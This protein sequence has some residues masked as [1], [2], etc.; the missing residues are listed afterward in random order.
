MLVIHKISPKFVRVL[1]NMYTKLEGIVKVNGQISQP[2]DIERGLR[3][4]C[5]MSPHLF[6]IYI[7]ELPELLQRA[8]CDPVLVHDKKINILMYAD[9]ML[10]LSY[11]Q[12]GLQ[13]ALYILEA[14]CNKWQLV[15]N[16]HKTKIMIFNKRKY[17]N[18]QFLYK[19][20]LLNITKTYIYLGI[21]ITPSGS[22]TQTT[23]DLSI[24]AK[25]ALFSL[26]SSLRKVQTNPQLTL[27]LFD[28]LIKPIALY[29]CD[30]WGAFGLRTRDLNSLLNVILDADHKSFE[31]LNTSVCKQALHINKKASNLGAKAEL[32]R[33]PMAVTII[34]SIV[35]YFHRLKHAKANSLL[36]CALQSQL[37]KTRNYGNTL[38]YPI[39]AI[40]LI[41]Q[42]GLENSFGQSITN[43]D[44]KTKLKSIGKAVKN[45]C[46]DYFTDR[47]L[48]NIN[49]LKSTDSKLVLF[50]E[51]KTNYLYEKY[52][53]SNC[54][55]KSSL[56]RFRLS[57]HNLP[58]E[59]GRYTRPPTERNLRI[60][61]FCKTSVG[62]EMH[63]LIHCKHEKLKKLRDKFL[64]LIYYQIPTL[65][66]ITEHELLLNLLNGE[67]PTIWPTLFEWLS[68][69]NLAY[70]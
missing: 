23:K 22:F 31:A 37:S 30:I 38:T 20:D 66:H 47:V 49:A 63:A 34:T 39:V 35:K 50:A 59:R 68:R 33:F 44:S 65:E 54:T 67:H 25:N 2:F 14:F 56:T 28:T 12:R 45:K 43:V 32:G 42:L 21:T 10:M 53:N 46:E 51:M 16:T 41:S 11:S 27:K 9:D 7:N 8:N 19:G 58:I 15:V 60:C 36:H 17:D 6:N 40:N 69:C 48:G 4:G 61:K 3:Q 29:G 52:I 1:H 13:R 62:N 5:N 70:K 57:S 18:L 26:S 24:K 64:S 55:Y